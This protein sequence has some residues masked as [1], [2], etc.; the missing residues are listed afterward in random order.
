MTSGMARSQ[1]GSKPRGARARTKAPGATR[2]ASV[3][4]VKPLERTVSAGHPWIFREALSGP[5]PAPGEVVYYLVSGETAGVESAPGYDA[6]GSPRSNPA[7][8]P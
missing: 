6:A 5:L 4:L 1:R 3:R 7:A 2:R 8:C